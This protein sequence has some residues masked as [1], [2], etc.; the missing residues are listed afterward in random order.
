MGNP[1]HQC[2]QS[3]PRIGADRHRCRVARQLIAADVDADHARQI[4]HTAAHI[5]VIIGRPQFGAHRKHRIRA[6]DQIAHRFQT[7]GG[8]HRQHMTRRHQPARVHRLHHRRIQPLRQFLQ[9][10][11]RLP[12]ATAY[13]DHHALCRVQGRHRPGYHIGVQGRAVGRAPGG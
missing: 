2:R 10:R 5:H 11:P 4:G 6:P 1:A 3:R 13:K 8:R 12:R 9:G 7:G